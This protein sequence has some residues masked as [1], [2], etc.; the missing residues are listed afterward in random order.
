MVLIERNIYPFTLPSKPR[1]LPLKK[2]KWHLN[3][4]PRTDKHVLP[5]GKCDH[6]AEHDLIQYDGFYRITL[7]VCCV[8]FTWDKNTPTVVVGSMHSLLY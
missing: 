3:K 1:A 4:A 8:R 2:H 6:G 5:K 7:C